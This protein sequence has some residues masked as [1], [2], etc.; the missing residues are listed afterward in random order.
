MAQWTPIQKTLHQNSQWQPLT[1]YDV[2]RQDTTA[3]LLLAEISHA[4]PFYPLAFIKAGEQFQFVTL[5]SLQPGLNLYVNPQGKWRVPYVPSVYRGYPFRLMTNSDTGELIFCFDQDSGLISETDADTPQP[6]AHPL[7]NDSNELAEKTASVF[8]FL[9]QCEQNKQLTQQAVDALAEHQLIVPWE[10][11]S[12]V[13]PEGEPLPIQGLYRIDEAALNQLPAEALQ[14]LQQRQAIAIAY[15][16]LYSQARLQGLTQL[17]RVHEA[18][19]KQQQPA[20][21]DLDQLFGEAEDDI[22]KF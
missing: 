6:A 3:P 10:I 20:D 18:E 5:H 9:Q 19:L 17:Y 14:T 21:V 7:F 1:G 15:G 2:A 22:F 12:K 13:S 8:S 4:L 11:K 16:Q